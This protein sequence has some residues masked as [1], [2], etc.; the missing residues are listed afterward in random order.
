M[1]YQL[2]MAVPRVA[3]VV[4]EGAAAAERDPVRLQL[5]APS[6]EVEREGRRIAVELVRAR[7]VAA[8]EVKVDCE[9]P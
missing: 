8:K 6:D 9:I 3:A 4:E 5:P 1:L 2:F 7:D